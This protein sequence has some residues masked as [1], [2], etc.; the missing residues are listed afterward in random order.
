MWFTSSS[1]DPCGVTVWL[2]ELSEA[3]RERESREREIERERERR[4][5]VCVVCE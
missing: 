1:P 3:E 4:E 2:C 5:Y